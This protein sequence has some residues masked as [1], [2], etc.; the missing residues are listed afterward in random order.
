AQRQFGWAPE[1]IIGHSFVEL[2]PVET[3]EQFRG[4]FAQ[5]LATGDSALVSRRRELSLLRRDGTVIP[6]ECSSCVLPSASGNRYSLFVHDI[7][8]RK[9]SEAALR[10]SQEQL[11]AIADNIPAVIAYIDREG[12][13]RYANAGHRSLLG[14]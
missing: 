1:E 13:L 4:Q 7:S 12:I 11:R 8:E 6:T 14:S 3:R 5:F 10:H 2:L 9:R